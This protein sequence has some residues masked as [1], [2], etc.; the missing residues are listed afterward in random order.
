MPPAWKTSN[1]HRS[2]ESRLLRLRQQFVI[3]HS[4]RPIRWSGYNLSRLLNLTGERP[5]RIKKMRAL[6]GL[7]GMGLQGCWP[8]QSGVFD[9]GEMWGRSGKPWA[10]VG[11]P[12]GVNAAEH[13]WLAALARFTPAIRVSINDR[14]SHYSR[15]TDHVRIELAAPHRPWTT[16]PATRKTRAV[17][18]E[19]RKALAEEFPTGSD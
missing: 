19:F 9:H 16:F 6:L 17:A 15:S 1:L 3:E 10:I 18:R 5:D 4:A 7:L 14:P 8:D 13:G 11:H 2:N 12:Y